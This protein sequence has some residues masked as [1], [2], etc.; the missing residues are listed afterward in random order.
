MI[1]GI[2]NEQYHTSP[3]LGRSTAWQVINSCPR[4]VKYD[5]DHPGSQ[6][7]ALVLGNAFHLA[8]MEPK[9]FEEEVEMKPRQIDGKSPLTK[10]YKEKFSE[11]QEEDPSRTW[12]SRSDWEMVSDMADSAHSHPWLKSTLEEGNYIIEGT[13]FFDCEGVRC[14]V[15]PDMFDPETGIIIDLKSTQ[16]ASE[17]GFRSSVKKFGYGFQ[18][19]WYQEGLKQMGHK[20]SDFVF[21][22]VEKKPP[23]LCACYRINQAEIDYQ[24]KEMKR[25]CRLWSQ[26]LEAETFPG[27]STEI[28]TL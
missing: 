8:T 6:S 27:Y 15:R 13:G 24:K 28:I 3:E 10:H 1:Q 11:L 18:V 17:R 19:A 16:D 7:S 12:L 2:T 9:L 20:V 22:A 23:Y 25:A 5:K 14:K 26:C 4:R 21:L